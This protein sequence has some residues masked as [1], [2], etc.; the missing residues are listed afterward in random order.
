ML[1]S[2][3]SSLCFIRGE[4]EHAVLWVRGYFLGN[5][6]EV[7]KVQVTPSSGSV[8]LKQHQVMTSVLEY[9]RIKGL[10]NVR[11]E[12]MITPGSDL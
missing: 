10:P 1:A 2:S 5:F 7:R 6:E 9:L 11:A 8:G 4:I 3:L 12:P